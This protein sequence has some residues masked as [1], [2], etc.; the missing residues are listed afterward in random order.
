MKRNLE[1]Q[2]KPSD[3]VLKNQI[4]VSDGIEL[5]TFSEKGV[6]KCYDL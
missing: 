4:L 1:L 5:P 2:I 3:A 6:N